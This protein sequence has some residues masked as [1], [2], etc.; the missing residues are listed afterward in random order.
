M[1]RGCSPGLTSPSCA[2]SAAGARG[3]R[4]WAR[5]W[6][7]GGRAAVLASGVPTV[8]LGGEAAPDAELQALS[9]VPA[10]VATEALAYLREG[11]VDNLR[12]L[13]RFLSDTV[14]LTGEGFEPPR[15]MPQ[16]GVL[17]SR[18]R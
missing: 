10:G 18:A 14:L 6:G 16:H 9:T 4:G 7:A 13:A 11:G 3:R 2:C 5:G 12:E 15:P 1:C 8:V 17:G